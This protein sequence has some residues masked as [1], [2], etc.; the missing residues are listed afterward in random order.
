MAVP[1]HLVCRHCGSP[2]EPGQEYCLECG[3]RLLPAR[4]AP[5]AAAWLVPSVV[6]LIVAGAGAAAAIAA[7]GDNSGG[8]RH[9]IVAVSPLRAAPA[10]PPPPPAK[11][12]AKGGKPGKRPAKLISWPLTN[13]YTVILASLP[14]KDGGAPARKR[15]IEALKN[16]LRQVGVLVSSSYPSLHPGYYIVFSGIYQS[17]EDAQAALPAARRHFKTAYARPIVR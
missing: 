11:T 7:G 3:S 12:R 17:Q 5:T 2:S 14:L 4:R 13:G 10:P 8:G 9:V 6:M 15:A 16:G 1:P